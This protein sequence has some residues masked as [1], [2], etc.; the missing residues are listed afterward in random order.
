MSIAK[1]AR[2]NQND[3]LHQEFLELRQQHEVT[4][5]EN[6]RLQTSYDRVVAEKL[7]LESRST[8]QVAEIQRQANTISMQTKSMASL[9]DT[10]AAAIQRCSE[11]EV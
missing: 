10:A 7:V 2:E 6:Q 11:L 3:I 1:A 4:L 8:Q 9:Q 5:A